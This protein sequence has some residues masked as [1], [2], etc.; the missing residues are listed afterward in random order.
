MTAIHSWV[1]SPDNHQRHRGKLHSDDLST[2]EPNHYNK[3]PSTK[4]NSIR[5]LNKTNDIKTQP[6]WRLLSL[7]RPAE[8]IGSIPQASMIYKSQQQINDRRQSE[9]YQQRYQT[10][11]T[12]SIPPLMSVRS[13][14]NTAAKLYKTANHTSSSHY[15]NDNMYY[16]SN[17]QIHQQQY[18]TYNTNNTSDISSAHTRNNGARQKKNS[19]NRTNTTNKK[20]NQSPE[21]T[22]TS[23]ID[24]TNSSLE[25]PKTTNE[26]VSIKKPNET[27]VLTSTTE[28]LAKEIEKSDDSGNGISGE[29]VAIKNDNETNVVQIENE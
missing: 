6:V 9:S 1:E 18:T 27:S 7:N 29:K 8:S 11:N 17:L 28:V 23:V 2:Q 21:K 22:K 14:V 13:D 12:A 16:D 20:T 25:K 24:E 26:E 19:T 4:T 15:D 10:I 3:Y 5:L